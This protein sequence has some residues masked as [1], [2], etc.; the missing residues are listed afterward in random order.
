MKVKL[1]K[2]NSRLVAGSATIVLTLRHT[3][4]CKPPRNFRREMR[5]RPIWISQA[6]GAVYKY[7]I[8]LSLSPKFSTD[9]VSINPN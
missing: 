3:H 8:S 6:K 7:L 5:H 4:A 2:K 9:P 1:K